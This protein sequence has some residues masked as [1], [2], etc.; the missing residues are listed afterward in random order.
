MITDNLN[1]L[2]VDDDALLR[3]VTKNVLRSFSAANIHEAADGAKA[4]DII[5]QKEE[6]PVDII[7]CDLNMPEMDGM[8]FMRHLG[9][10]RCDVSVIIV[11]AQD[12]ALLGAVAKMAAAYGLRLLG[13]AQKPIQHEHLE[14]L[15]VKHKSLPPKKAARPARP[16][17]SL[18]E[19][20]Q[21]ITEKQFEPFF[22]PKVA[23]ETG[24][25]TGAEALARWRHPQHGVVTPYAFIETLER[26]G[27]ILGLTLIILEK[28][29]VACKTLHDKGHMIPI[30]V[31]LSLDLLGDPALSEKIT[32]V[33][34]SAGIKPQDIILEI[35]ETAAM[36]DI[37]HSL[38]NL[39]RLKMHGF[40]LSVDDYGTGFSNMQQI[41]RVAFSELK[42]DQSFVKD[43]ANNNDLCV[44]LQSN[45]DMAHKLKMAC[46]A[47]G[48][49][50]KE[51]WDTLKNMGCDMAQGYFIAKPMSLSSFVDFC[52]HYKD[53]A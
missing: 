35:T 21:G 47:E 7:L 26:N 6:H 46:I 41:M 40:H 22:Q 39:A 15:I 10:E 25:I 53:K 34:K 16:V 43:C 14:A 36:T 33:V 32:Q 11:S 48:V 28:A 51:D 12:D 45:I 19:I 1:F 24:A 30:S 9:E 37:A 42:I 4:L 49:E 13:A 31:N 20:L 38:E 18:D 8:E 5:K 50:T 3:Q 29:A 23:F 27:N 17:F 2:V 44:M 52:S